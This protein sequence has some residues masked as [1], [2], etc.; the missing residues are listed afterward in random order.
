MSNESQV[1]DTL[2][3]IS[4]GDEHMSF[5]TAATINL[6]G[7]ALRRIHGRVLFGPS[8]VR[9]IAAIVNILFEHSTA[10]PEVPTIR[11]RELT[12]DERNGVLQGV[13][14]A[15]EKPQTITRINPG[16]RV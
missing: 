10:E 5:I 13:T 15:V 16:R 9:A 11:T 7:E 8:D 6:Y 3:G 12:E 14:A 2:V 4:T 1:R